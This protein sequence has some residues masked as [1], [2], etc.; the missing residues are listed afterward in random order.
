MLEYQTWATIQSKGRSLSS[1]APPLSTSKTTP[2]LTRT[3]RNFPT[4]DRGLLPVGFPYSI[5]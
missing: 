4:W 2:V 5:Q 3:F 1:I